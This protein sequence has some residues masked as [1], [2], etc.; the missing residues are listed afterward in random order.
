[1]FAPT[2]CYDLDFPRSSGIRKGF[3]L[4]RCAEILVLLSLQYCL[5]QQWMLP[6]LRTFDRPLNQYST[7]QNIERL[8][9]LTLPNHL[10]NG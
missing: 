5:S 3:I 7:L 6:I 1:M 8:L 2:F 10:L 4:R 9:R